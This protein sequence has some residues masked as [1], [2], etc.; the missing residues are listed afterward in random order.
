M[1]VHYTPRPQCERQVGVRLTLMYNAVTIPVAKF[2]PHNAE[3][4]EHYCHRHLSEE[5]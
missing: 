1:G 2:C 3:P 4:G 5:D